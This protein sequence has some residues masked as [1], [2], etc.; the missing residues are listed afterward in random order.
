M[1]AKWIWAGVFGLAGSAA[2]YLAIVTRSVTGS[3]GWFFAVFA[4]LL[5]TLAAGA[6]APKREPAAVPT[7]FVSHCFLVVAILVTVVLLIVAVVLP[8]ILGKR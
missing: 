8:L 2:I 4:S 3:E 6:V 5:F 7:K 1:K